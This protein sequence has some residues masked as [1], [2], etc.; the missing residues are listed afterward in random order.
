ML[1]K[2]IIRWELI[3]FTFYVKICPLRRIKVHIP[4]VIRADGSL[5]VQKKFSEWN[6]ISP[7]Y[8]P[9][10]QDSTKKVEFTRLISS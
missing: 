2:K 6:S 3:N 4:E 9:I 7:N 8:F 5:K 10:P 1:I